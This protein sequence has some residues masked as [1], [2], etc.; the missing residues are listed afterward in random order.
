MPAGKIAAFPQ[1][2]SVEGLNEGF[3]VQDAGGQPL[4]YVYFED[5]TAVANVDAVN[6]ARQGQA[7][8][9]PKALESTSIIR[10]AKLKRVRHNQKRSQLAKHR[11]SVSKNFKRR[12]AKFYT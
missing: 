12:C 6:L 9:A 4:A 5:E 1:L 11:S 7:H 2:W 3:V 10:S 8:P